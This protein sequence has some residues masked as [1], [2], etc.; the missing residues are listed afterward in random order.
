MVALVT[1]GKKQ[2]WPSEWFIGGGRRVVERKGGNRV[3]GPGEQ[4]KC[5]GQGWE[6]ERPF[7][8]VQ[9]APGAGCELDL[10]Q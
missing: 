6:E 7:F 4:S 2:G 1:M 10:G 9:R 3:V 5:L 8:L